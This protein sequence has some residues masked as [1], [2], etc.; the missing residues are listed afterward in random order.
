MPDTESTTGTETLAEAT[1]ESPLGVG[2]E[3]EGASETP[4]ATPPTPEQLAADLKRARNGQAAE[5]RRAAELQRQLEAQQAQMNQMWEWQ[6]QQAAVPQRP[7]EPQVAYGRD[8]LTSEERKRYSNAIIDGNEAA[9]EELEAAKQERLRQR[10]T[11]EMQEQQNQNQAL[12]QAA[13][14][15]T[16]FMDSEAPELKK[17][18]DPIGQEMRSRYQELIADPKMR[19]NLGY[20]VQTPQ[21]PQY[22]TILALAVKDV[23]AKHAS[24]R[25]Q[26]SAAAVE[27]D[28]PNVERS[29]RPAGR[30][31][32]KFNAFKHMSPGEREMVDNIKNKRDGSYSYQKWWDRLNPAEKDRRLAAGKP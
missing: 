3:V 23:R 14:S 7:A 18:G 5:Q 29:S 17:P 31:S 20:A 12:N 24:A 1:V 2:A 19:W 27:D 28:M 13:S 9:L 25:A 11:R 15:F 22:P 32:A 16:E 10:M 6:R 30:P 8:G 4:P 26:S 21:G